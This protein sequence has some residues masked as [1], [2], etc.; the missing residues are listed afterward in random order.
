MEVM[1][2]VVKKKYDIPEELWSVF[3]RPPLRHNESCPQYEAVRAGIIE[4]IGPR[5]KLEWLLVD[6]I[7]NF[8][9][10]I[11]RLRR[12]K[13]AIVSLTWREALSK[14]LEAHMDGDV[15]VRSRVA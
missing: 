8:T 3:V 6:D 4:T 7:V 5:N 9:W 2:E 14:I 11:R 13:A 12:D 15:Q 10:E 1:K